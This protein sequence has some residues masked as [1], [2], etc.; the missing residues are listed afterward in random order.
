MQLKDWLES[1][2]LKPY[3]IVVGTGVA[4]STI[5]RAL[6]QNNS[7][8]TIASALAISKFTGGAVALE[9]LL[10]EDQ[11]RA[12]EQQQEYNEETVRENKQKIRLRS[13][14]QYVRRK[15]NIESEEQ[16]RQLLSEAM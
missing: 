11:R 13:T 15:F 10:N 2:S 4:Q 8:L 7:R 1:K 6:E 5:Q 3:D 12:V 14:L 9:D 16:M